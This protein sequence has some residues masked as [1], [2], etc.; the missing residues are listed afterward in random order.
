MYQERCALAVDT[1]ERKDA[2]A[3]RVLRRSQGV[4]PLSGRESCAEIQARGS[5]HARGFCAWWG[6]GVPWIGIRAAIAARYGKRM[7]IFASI[8][9]GC[10]AVT[11]C[12]A[13][14]FEFIPIPPGGKGALLLIELLSGA[15]AQ[16]RTRGLGGL[17]VVD[18]RLRIVQ[19]NFPQCLRRLLRCYAC[20]HRFGFG[21][22]LGSLLLFSSLLPAS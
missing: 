22:V 17:K 1:I 11:D 15:N 21:V 19:F 14:F 9:A 4:M 16:R 10:Y 20:P 7:S 5:Q 12:R 18:C 13:V 8:D 6:A 2:S 3:I